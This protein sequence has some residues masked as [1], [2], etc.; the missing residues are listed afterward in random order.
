MPFL[1]DAPLVKF[2]YLLVTRVPGDGY[3]GGQSE[4]SE[5]NLEPERTD[6]A[7]HRRAG[8]IAEIPKL[9]ALQEN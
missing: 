5:E 2:L 3:R 7:K 4:S 8:E 6:G 9:L 1:K